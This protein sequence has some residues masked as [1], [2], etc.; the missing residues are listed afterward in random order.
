M[1]AL[2]ITSSPPA[3]CLMSSV[4]RNSC[5]FLCNVP[6]WYRS[7]NVLRACLFS[8]WTVK[9]SELSLNVRRLVAA[10]S[11][12]SLKASTNSLSEARAPCWRIIPVPT[13]KDIPLTVENL[14]SIFIAVGINRFIYILKKKVGNLHFIALWYRITVVLWSMIKTIRNYEYLNIKNILHH[15]AWPCTQMLYL[16]I[17]VT[18][19]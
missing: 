2:R 7:H 1:Y 4:T 13:A 19:D 15:L 14:Q 8:A 17:L 12:A 10:G 9:H 6:S 3:S 16:I 18:S 5:R 11:T